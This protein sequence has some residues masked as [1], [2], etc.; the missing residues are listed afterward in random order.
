[1]KTGLFTILYSMDKSIWGD[2]VN[3]NKYLSTISLLFCMLIGIIWGGSRYIESLFDWNIEVSL[4]ASL[5]MVCVLIGYNIA[6][7]IIATD[8]AKIALL[9]TLMMLVIMVLGF[10]A[11][12]IGSVILL[13]ILTLVIVIYLFITFIQLLLNGGPNDGK[14]R[15]KL[16]NGDV[17]TEQKGL[18]GESYYTGSSGKSYDTNDGGDSFYE[19]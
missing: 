17:V 14:R 18:M 6:E 11:G 3:P 4:T 19:K 12:L 9:R 1:M 8:S 15:W 16:D 10:V 5:A 13:A 2:R 7:S